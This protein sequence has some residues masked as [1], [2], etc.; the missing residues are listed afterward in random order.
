MSAQCP[1]YP[2]IGRRADI[3]GCLKRAKALNRLRDSLLPDRL[4][5][6]RWPRGISRGLILKGKSL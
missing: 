5:R 2:E 1:D 3:D 4:S 6:D